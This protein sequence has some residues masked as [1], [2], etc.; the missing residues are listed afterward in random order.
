MYPSVVEMGLVVTAD[1]VV[2]DLEIF[3]SVHIKTSE[4]ANT[5]SDL[6]E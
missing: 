2:D 5:T 4:I 1:A 6:E 3:G